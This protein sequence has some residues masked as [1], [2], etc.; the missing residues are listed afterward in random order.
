M[1]KRPILAVSLFVAVFFPLQAGA[2]DF[3][4][5]AFVHTGGTGFAYAAPDR[6][7]ID[8]EVSVFNA[9]PAAA[10]QA[11]EARLG[12]IRSVLDRAQLPGDDIDIRDVRREFR[13]GEPGV[14]TYDL[15]AGVHIKVKDLSKWKALVGALIVMPDLD[16]FLVG[17][18]TSRREQIEAELTAQALGNA[19]RKG[20]NIAAGVGRKLGVASAVSVGDLKNV[21]RAIG[22]GG[23][24][25]IAYR[26]PVQA[27]P[28][29]EGLLMV[30]PMKLSQSVDVIYRFK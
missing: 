11:I 3:P 13:K 27:D 6:G 4:D 24:Q 26:N 25:T 10:L 16:G 22:L 8:F 9:D 2:A 19:R 17:F 29:R 7:E 20:E 30:V 14:P 23:V 28:E 21:T 5:Y 1:F 18:D 15:K 12:Q